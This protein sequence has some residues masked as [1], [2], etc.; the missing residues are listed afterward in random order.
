MAWRGKELFSGSEGEAMAFSEQQIKLLE[1]PL[2]RDAVKTRE[3]SNRK[4]S[5]VEG[6]HVIA[7]ANRIFGFDGWS[8]STVE[9]CCVVERERLI[10]QQAKPGW[11]VSYVA[12][13]TITAGNV[14]HDGYGTG[15]GIDLDL[16]QAH[17]S[18]I[19]EAETDAQK[20]AL[21]NFG[22]PFGLALY[23]KEQ[24]NVAE[25]VDQSRLDFIEAC[26]ASIARIGA[27]PDKNDVLRWWNSEAEKKKRDDFDLS[28]AERLL[29]KTLVTD[30]VAKHP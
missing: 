6:W 13:V 15:H 28:A 11:G 10:G 12:R 14:T 22:H 18:A 7:E 17:E 25:P 2:S 29:L 21:K 19:K 16:G 8:T 4:L 23:D 24:L 5:Y 20:R 1:A 9:M 30:T 26:K 27:H 3:Q